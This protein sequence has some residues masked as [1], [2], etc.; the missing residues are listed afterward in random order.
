MYNIINFPRITRVLEIES[1]SY[2]SGGKK[3]SC[4]ESPID[5]YEK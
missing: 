1:I 5:M 3:F 4:I 2:E